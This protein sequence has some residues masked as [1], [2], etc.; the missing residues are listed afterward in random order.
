MIRGF[1]TRSGCSRF[2]AR[3]PVAQA[4]GFF[5]PAQ[6]ALLSTLGLGSY[7]GD[8]DEGT[9]RGYTN[10]ASAALRG[11][12][13][14]IDTSLNYRNQLSE[15]A[16]APALKTVARDETVVCT[17]AGYL[18]P[19]AIPPGLPAG[20]V[21]GGTHSMEPAFLRHQL[22][23]SRENLNLETIDV[24]Y[25]HNPETQLRFVSPPEFYARA[26]AA[27]ESLESLAADGKIRYYGT[28]TWDGYRRGAQPDA[29]SLPRLVSLAREVAG[30]AHRFRFI[31]LPFNL[32]MPEA[33]TRALEGGVTVLDQARESGVTVIASA[34]L[35][36]ARLARGLP[37]VV[38]EK[39]RGPR[40]DAQ[41]AI[42][43][44]RSAPGITA[45]LVGMSQVEHV[46]ENLGVAA[47]PP[48]AP[49]EFALIFR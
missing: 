45:A 21:A 44:T 40:T 49:E 7:L 37:P 1:A 42:Q 41:R 19:G 46:T 6:D 25:L 39:I 48:A 14:L 24:F 29:L 4:A 2:A 23:L 12:I 15:R 47:I 20:G 30:D 11:G 43:F 35:L 5:R 17:K 28:A 32:G 16:L 3:F 27:F 33:L 10:A 9:D 36:Q 13:N 8:L 38:A 22:E 31:Q 26:R 18:V 34:S